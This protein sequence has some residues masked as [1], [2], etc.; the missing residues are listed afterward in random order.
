[1]P[2]EQLSILG[3]D[4]IQLE[5]PPECEETARAFYAGVLGLVEIEKPE[6]LR[7]RGGVWFMCGLQQIHI[8]VVESFMPQLKGHPALEVRHL[9]AWRERL[10]AAHI[11]IK[12]DEPLPGWPQR[13]Y[14]NGDQFRMD[15]RPTAQWSRLATGRSD[16][17]GTKTTAPHSSSN[18]P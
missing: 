17:P 18:Q 7:P 13:R 11:S 16:D 8:G 15:G 4:H 5:A 3:I 14:S 12:E 2:E 10:E 1:M 6:H 9:S